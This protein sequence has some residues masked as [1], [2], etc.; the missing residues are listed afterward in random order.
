MNL[1]ILTEEKP[2]ISVL[3]EILELYQNEFKGNYSIISDLIVTPMMDHNSAFT[4]KYELTGVEIN[5]KSKVFIKIVS[6]NSSFLDF[7]VIERTQEPN[8]VEDNNIIFGVEETKTSDHESRN[9]GVFQR[10]SKFVYI[11]SYFDSL[12]LYMLYNEDLEQDSM[13]KPSPTN[14][15]GTNLLLTMGVK[16]IGKP[17]DTWF[18]D[19]RSI[20]ELIAFKNSMRRPPKSNIPIL[21]DK[22]EHKIE[23]SG[24]LSKPSDKGNIG[25]D[26][27]IGAITA[28]AYT[29]RILG[30]NKNI[31][32]TKHGVSQKY[33]NRATIKNKFLLIARELDLHL[34]GVTIKNLDASPPYYWK[35]ETKSEKIASIMYHIISENRGHTA[36]YHNHAGCERSYFRTQNNKLITIPKKNSNNELLYIPDLIIKDDRNKLILLIEGKQLSTIDNGVDELNQF[37]DIETDYIN[38][39]YPAY[40]VKRCLTIFGGKLNRLPNDKVG[41]YLSDNGKYYENSSIVNSN[42]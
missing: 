41:F 28:I 38:V 40:N 16:I 10:I 36:I 2:R 39:Y 23:I 12:P 14:V 21:I 30:W 18:N 37:D 22:F 27:N 24:R 25:H 7:L 17:T 1:W 6:G 5:E 13:K 8:P 11:K 4:F 9:T 34:N 31:T 33:L 42:D 26:P 15:F 29:L 19:F 3:K 20:D 35:Y 32:I